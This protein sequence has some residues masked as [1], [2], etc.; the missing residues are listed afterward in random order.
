[1]NFQQFENPKYR[2]ED[3]FAREEID[4]YYDSDFLDEL[5][6]T[7][8]DISKEQYFKDLIFTTAGENIDLKSELRKVLK[9]KPGIEKDE[10][11]KIYKERIA[12]QQI[13]FLELS[14]KMN[15][16]FYES[17]QKEETPEVLSVEMQPLIEKYANLYKF[18]IEQVKII[19]R[20][21]LSFFAKNIAVK[22]VY[23]R[24]RGN[25]NDIFRH[26]FS[27]SPQ[28]DIE[29][30][31]G[32]TSLTFLC[33]NPVDYSRIYLSKPSGQI[34]GDDLEKSNRSGGVFMYGAPREDLE[35]TLIATNGVSP[36]HRRNVV[37][38]E[39][40][41]AYNSLFLGALNHFE[42]TAL[43]LVFDTLQS[44]EKKQALVNAYCHG[45]INRASE[46]AKDEILAYNADGSSG[47]YIVDTLLK[48]EKEGGIYEYFNV[49]QTLTDISKII[50]QSGEDP[51]PY[52]DRARVI[53]TKQYE[54]LLREGVDAYDHL[55]FD[56]K[57][58]HEEAVA[59]LVTQPL[60]RW[61]KTVN[62]APEKEEIDY[63]Q[64]EN[65]PDKKEERQFVSIRDYVIYE[66]S[67]LDLISP[68]AK[69]KLEILFETMKDND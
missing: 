65:V 49:D 42:G 21:I 53:L 58:E 32:P 62:S 12:L 30:Q 11:L 48:S 69:E 56:K 20:I 57:Y 17:T 4:E 35:G 15:E 55:I 36:W 60:N 66:Q 22:D 64:N 16:I 34:N 23:H 51:A 26:V 14:I 33:A 27:G 39:R 41:H 50:K 37:I 18:T 5:A 19:E 3:F 10:A 59:L 13:G 61:K 38:H 68:E 54:R 1:M 6:F 43:D 31:L 25:G 40:Q 63:N 47:Y 28:N 67:F 45:V 8:Q 52:M 29:V 7:S 2:N 24:H 9:L 46:R 44:I